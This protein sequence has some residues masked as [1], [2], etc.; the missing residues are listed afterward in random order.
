MWPFDYFKKLKE[1]RLKAEAEKRAE[2]VRIEK[3]RYNIIK[4]YIQKHIDAVER[5]E[6]AKRDSYMELFNKEAEKNNSICPKC[7]HSNVFQV[8]HR[9][10]G[11]IT[12]SLDSKSESLF[13]AGLFGGGY[14]HSSA[15]GTLNGQF[16]TLKVNKCGDCNHE[17]EYVD[18]IGIVFS[19]DYYPQKVDYSRDVPYFIEDCH[20]AIED[21]KNFDPSKI[22]EECNTL[23][24][25]EAQLISRLKDKCWYKTVS[26]LSVELLH[27]YTSRY[28]YRIS[29]TCAKSALIPF[30]EKEVDEYMG[31]FTAEWED[32]LVNKLGFKKHFNK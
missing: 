1:A 26:K 20:D 10:K 16:D 17:W 30:H 2:I 21:L 19:S 22:T 31:T 28:S 24:E 3:E 25:K 12:G 6:D 13:R 27:Y 15:K 5:L 9:P 29:N 8:Y 11:E 23:E 4:S 7:K 14:Y 18:L 32:F